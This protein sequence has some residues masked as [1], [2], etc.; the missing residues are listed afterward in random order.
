M[1]G[2]PESETGD[3]SIVAPDPDDPEPVWQT[4]GS[5][6]DAFADVPYDEE[7]RAALMARE[8]LQAADSECAARIRLDSEADGTGID[9]DARSDLEWALRTLGLRGSP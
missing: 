9:S 4:Y 2:E 1:H 7:H 8:R 6:A 5:L 3:W